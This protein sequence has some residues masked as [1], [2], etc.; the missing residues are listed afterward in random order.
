MLKSIVIRLAKDSG[1]S[2]HFLLKNEGKKATYDNA[3]IVN[4]KKQKS[5]K[6]QTLA[7]DK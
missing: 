3:N 7:I 4:D 5:V 1:L 2:K 6:Y